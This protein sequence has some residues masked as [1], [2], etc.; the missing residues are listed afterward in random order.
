MG[1]GLKKPKNYKGLNKYHENLNNEEQLHFNY[2]INNNYRISP[3]PATKGLFP[4]SWY[5]EVR[6]GLYKKGEKAHISP[7]SYDDKG[8]WPAIKKA[9]KYYYEKRT[10]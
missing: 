5:V 8:I 7:I 1:S 6:L 2:C 3:K 10:K 9:R 4:D